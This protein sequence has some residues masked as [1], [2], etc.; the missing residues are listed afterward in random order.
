[1]NLAVACRA[2]VK[3]HAFNI[4]RHTIAIPPIPPYGSRKAVVKAI[5]RP[6]ATEG[7]QL[8]VNPDSY[9]AVAILLQTWF[10]D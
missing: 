6:K 9:T 3:A 5:G 7:T 1:M 10:R 8:H 2:D 4:A